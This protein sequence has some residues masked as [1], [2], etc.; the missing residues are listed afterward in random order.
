M[1]LAKKIAMDPKE[2]M[3]R[4]LLD[5]H[6]SETTSNVPIWMWELIEKLIDNGWTKI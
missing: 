2:E 5:L 4:D 6:P 3:A 1:K